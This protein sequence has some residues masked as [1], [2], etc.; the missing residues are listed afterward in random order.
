MPSPEGYQLSTWDGPTG[1]GGGP[2]TYLT[3]NFGLLDTQ[4]FVGDG[5]APARPPFSV[6]TMDLT[7]PAADPKMIAAYAKV[8]DA[9]RL[10]LL[11]GAAKLGSAS[12]LLQGQQAFARQLMDINA[13]SIGALVDAD[14][15]EASTRLKALQ[16]QQQ[17]GLQSLSLA[18]GA[19]QAVLALFRQ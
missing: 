19:S 12:A 14:M 7:A 17:L 10:K 8:V 11:D 6:T 16:T 1:I 2:T 13:S 3:W 9:T 5:L 18:N 15:E 4:Y